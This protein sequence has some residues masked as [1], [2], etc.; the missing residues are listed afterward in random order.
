MIWGGASRSSS[1]ALS[2]SVLVFVNGCFIGRNDNGYAPFRFDLTRLPELMARRTTLS[3][4]VDASFGDGWFYEGAGVY[5]H[6]WLTKTD[7]VHLGKWDS[8]V[9]TAVEWRC[10][11]ALAYHGGENHGKQT[12][13]AIVQ[14]EDSR[15]L[16]Q[17]R[18][19]GRSAR[20][21]D[22]CRWVSNVFRDG[23]TGQCGTVV[24]GRAESVFGDC[25]VETDGKVRDAERVSFGRAYGQVRR[26]KRIL[27]QRPIDQ[28]PGHM[29][30]PG[31]CRG[32]GGV[33]G[34][35]RAA[36]VTSRPWRSRM[37]A[38]SAMPG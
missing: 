28:D 27:S 34:P 10:R 29:Q 15:R 33:A 11:D 35:N 21:D 14:L 17:D 13:N 5:R 1:M 12:E 31:P 2:A 18:G 19:H 4:R 26:G 38:Y 3:L 6:V 32:R 24:G 20:A 22:C 25:T 37:A 8:T 23:A 7:A 30:S 36:K 9:R 16:R